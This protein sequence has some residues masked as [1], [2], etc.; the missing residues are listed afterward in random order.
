MGNLIGRTIAGY[1]ITG[2]IGSGG[3]G[4]V[5]RA[6]DGTRTVAI[7]V[8]PADKASDLRL[9]R[10]FSREAK[11]SGALSH[12]NVAQILE[13]GET[14]GIRFI[15]MEYVNGQA[16]DTRMSRPFDI[17]EVLQI[18]L[19][20]AE[21]LDAAHSKGIVHR[22]IKPGNVMITKENHVKVLDFGLAKLM[23]PSFVDPRGELGLTTQTEMGTTIGTVFYMSPEQAIGAPV[24][25]RS[26]I[27]SL[28]VLLYEMTTGRRPFE[29]RS[30]VE[31][32]EQILHSQP[33]AIALFNPRAGS[34]ID[35]MI[36]KCMDKDPR[37][38]YQSA[39]DLVVDLRI[40]IQ[41]PE[42]QPANAQSFAVE[43]KSHRARMLV[44]NAL[45]LV[46]LLAIVLYVAK[47]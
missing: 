11:A 22:D 26:D 36:R 20:I 21:A 6:N 9:M 45:L 10:R 13:V 5:Y 15:V 44:G 24:D 25:Y 18:G 30:I 28:G 1:H 38:R 2:Q 19:Q 16:L 43:K 39:Q 23:D 14:E 35:R 31:T 47:C 29:S 42:E 33:E 4:V 12:P 40:L 41:N 37:K 34:G 3:M 8:L 7:K 27:F 17:S 32:V 46:L